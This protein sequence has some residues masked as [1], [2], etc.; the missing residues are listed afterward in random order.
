MLLWLAISASVLA[1]GPNE[2]YLRIYEVMDQA[3]ELSQ[4]GQTEA[5]KAKYREVQA[6]LL[7]F[8]QKNPTWNVKVVT[9]RLNYV[10]ERIA[11]L[12]QPAVAPPAETAAPKQLEAKPQ[13]KPAAAL[14]AAQV[15]LLEAGAEPRRVLRLQIKPGDK[16]T[17]AM[18][19]KTGMDMGMG[20]AAGQAMQL[21]TIQMAM[22]VT[23]TGVS[24]E[25]DIAYAMT[26]GETSLAD[27][28]GALP[29][30]A[31]AMKASLNSIKGLTSKGTT[32]NRGISK[33]TE[34]K[35]PAG[36]DPQ[37]RQSMEQMKD[38][39]SNMTV[40]LP[41]EAI[42]PGAKWEVSK[43]VKSQGMTINQTTTFELL[44][45]E[46][47]LLKV[48]STIAQQAANQKIQSPAM[49]GLNLDLTKMTGAGSGEITFDLTRLLPTLATTK[50]H[51]EVSMGVNIGGQNQTMTRKTDLELRLE[52]K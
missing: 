9:Y 15:R 48:K 52:S 43:V 37:T 3:D 46:G 6:D 20:E 30:V 28:A 13:S 23:I 17:L 25:G 41:E 50:S 19:V 39:M 27:E 7:K 35:V 32:S 10:T 47:D 2:Q 11:A 24:A 26:I 16:Q 22:D 21:P 42:G 1:E 14:T 12:S 31:E 45:I 38:S 34:L 44:S 8:R 18:T 29:Q 49:P 51:S 36:A 33:E 40:G 5:A 4:S